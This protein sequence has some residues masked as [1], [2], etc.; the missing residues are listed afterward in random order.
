MAEPIFSNLPTNKVYRLMSTTPDD[1]YT[2]NFT[3][4]QGIV[5]QITVQTNLSVTLPFWIDFSKFLQLH[6]FQ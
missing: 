5:P 4:C 2:L 3:Q 1:E 6:V